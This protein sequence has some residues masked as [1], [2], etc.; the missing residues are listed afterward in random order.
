MKENKDVSAGDV[1]EEKSRVVIRTV[2]QFS[3]PQ[4]VRDTI[5]AY[6]DS[7][8]VYVKDVADV[9]VDNAKP[10]RVCRHKAKVHQLHQS[11]KA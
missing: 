5:V 2:G 9:R 1:W 7:A 10:D 6:R 8:P 11:S 3:S 4:Q